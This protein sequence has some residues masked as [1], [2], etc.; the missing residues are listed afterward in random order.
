MSTADGEAENID[1]AVRPTLAEVLA[2]GVPKTGI[3]EPA[4]FWRR[5]SAFLL[6]V[7]ILAI[8]GQVIALAL[9]SVLF[10]LGPYARIPGQFLALLYFGLMDSFVGNGQTLGKRLVG[11][12]VRN[13]EGQPIGIGRSMLRTLIWLVPETMNG[14]SA[15]V[16]S[17]PIV[18]AITTVMVAGVGGAVVTTMIF[19]R[20]SR[21]GLHD[22]L[23]DTYV[24]RV[25]GMPVAALPKASRRQWI[26]SGAMMSF[27]VLLIIGLWILAPRIMQSNLERITNLQNALESDRRFFTAGV[28][29]ETF[30]D[31]KR[32]H[33]LRLNVWIKGLPQESTRTVVMNEIAGLALTKV[34]D[35]DR[36]DLVR[37]DLNSAYDFG[38][39]W[40]NTSHY[41]A[42][43]VRTWRERVGTR[44]VR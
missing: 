17:N 35:I 13:A 2:S 10:E 38:I 6:D 8:A 26:L 18:G 21:Q 34:R 39:A 7:I 31:Q 20:R 36:F 23:T 19:N 33:M 11:V 5:F 3:R 9:S 43:T 22:M 37:I 12:G 29:D 40:G 41:D 24:L 25:G 32:T 14:W 44:A 16:M 15:P 27:S 1:S 4:G 28:I 30:Y 42:E